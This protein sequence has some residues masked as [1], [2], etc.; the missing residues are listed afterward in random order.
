MCALRIRTETK[1]PYI[2]LSDNGQV[3]STPTLF[4][5]ARYFKVSSSPRHNCFSP[6]NSSLGAAKSPTIP[7]HRIW[8]IGCSISDL[9][10]FRNSKTAQGSGACLWRICTETEGHDPLHVQ[11][12]RCHCPAFPCMSNYFPCMSIDKPVALS[13]DKARACLIKGQVTKSE[14]FLRPA[15]QFSEGIL[16]YGKENWR[17]R[18]GKRPAF[19][20]FDNFQTRPR[21]PK[22][23]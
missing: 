2:L 10:L 5:S 12:R 21:A 15:S 13:Y 23:C 6:A 18:S 1:R 14:E 3:P 11:I 17:C 4:I 7:L 16:A 19:Q 20:R 9:P 8:D 22:V